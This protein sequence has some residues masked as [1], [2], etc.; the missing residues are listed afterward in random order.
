M[1]KKIWSRP[2][3]EVET[4]MANE[5]IAKCSDIH[6][7]YFAFKCDAGGGHAGDVWQGGELKNGQLVGGKNLTPGLINY[8]YACGATHYV[9]EADK[10]A[11]FF[12]GYYN[13]SPS[14]D[15]TYGDFVPVV[16]WTDN[17]TNVHCTEDLMEKI[18]V[19]T[20]NK[21]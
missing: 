9:A 13:P 10:D 6:N 19:V 1:E 2:M 21:S 5:Y 17:G 7:K 3:A 16:I 20:G 14:L 11:T 12:R 18:E 15:S 4:F 8:F